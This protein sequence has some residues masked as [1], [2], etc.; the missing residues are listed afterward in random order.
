MSVLAI[1][2]FHL[3][4]N[5]LTYLSSTCCRVI[6]FSSQRWWI[7]LS[8]I[9]EGWFPAFTLA[10]M[11]VHVGIPTTAHI[12]NLWLYFAWHRRTPVCVCPSVRQ[13]KRFWLAP[14]MIRSCER[15][16][17]TRYPSPLPIPRNTSHRLSKLFRS[18]SGTSCFPPLNEYTT[19]TMPL[20]N[21]KRTASHRMISSM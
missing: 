20:V 13:S 16:G 8:A 21:E 4:S 9:A 7:N 5:S 6:A 17:L 18:E 3:I 1:A 15:S 11:W 12:F 2:A 19:N 10:Q 14:R